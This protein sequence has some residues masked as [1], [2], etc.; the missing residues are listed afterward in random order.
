MGQHRIFNQIFNGGFTLISFA[1]TGF[2]ALPSWAACTPDPFGGE[3][4]TP[5]AI[6]PTPPTS[7]PTPITPSS[8]PAAALPLV[9]INRGFTNL[10]PIAAYSNWQIFS[11]QLLDPLPQKIPAATANLVAPGPEINTDPAYRFANNPGAYYSERDGWRLR[12]WG[13]TSGGTLLPAANGYGSS[14]LIGGYSAGLKLDYAIT[15]RF[16]AGI[17][18]RIAEQNIQ[19]GGI[20]W[21]NSS[22]VNLQETGGGIFAQYQTPDWFLDGALGIDAVTGTSPI[23]IFSSNLIGIRS[24]HTSSSGSA[25]NAAI[26]GGLRWKLSES[27][28]LE[29]SLLLS[30]SN[31]NLAGVNSSI[32]GLDLGVTWKAPMRD[33]KNLF[34]PALRLA[35]LQRGFLGNVPNSPVSMATSGLGL[36]GQLNYTFANNTVIYAR[37]G[38]ELYS[39][40]PLWNVGGGLQLRF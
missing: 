22:S 6:L 28:L 9:E 27:Q 32:G 19:A 39:S 20:R 13:G 21:F 23:Q 37:G 7:T 24:Y 40:S 15:P 14:K 29:P 17:F 10:A 11:Q 16:R 5:D 25:F 3:V 33:G 36:Q 1:L 4:C 8:S 34:T 30:S 18:G 12:A 35:W 2:S 26:Q 38:A 31:L